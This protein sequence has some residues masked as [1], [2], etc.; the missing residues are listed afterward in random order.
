MIARELRLRGA[1]DFDRVRRLGHTQQTR[2]VVLKVLPNDLDHNQYGFAAGKR[3]GNAVRRNRAKRLM[4][5]AVRAYHPTLR[6]GFDLVFIARNNFGESARLADIQPEVGEL[7]RRAG[8]RH[9]T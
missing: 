6:T 4:R 7:L 1:M 2:Q 8:L 9:E 5:E 3:M